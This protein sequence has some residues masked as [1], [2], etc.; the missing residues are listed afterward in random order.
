MT[1]TFPERADKFQGADVD[2]ID[3]RLLQLLQEDASR[4]LKTL[5][6]AVGLSRS[7]VREEDTTTCGRFLVTA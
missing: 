7:S 1:A 5:A 3:R 6:H 2:D 4:P